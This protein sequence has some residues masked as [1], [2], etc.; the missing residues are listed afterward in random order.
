M[1]GKLR[2]LVRTNMVLY[3]LLLLVF[4]GLTA[5]LSPLLAAGEVAAALLVWYVSRRRNKVMQ[6]QLHQYVERISGGA[7]TAKTSNML[8]APMP[9][10]VFNPDSEDVLWANDLFAELPGV[11]E[12]IYESRVRD[13]VKGFETHW[14][15]EGKPE[16]P[17]VFTWN[18][19][20]YRVFGCLSQ[21]EEKGRFGVLATTYWMDVTDLEHM[22]S[23]LEETKPVAAIV[24]IDNYE[25]LM[26]ACPE[27]KRSAIRAA[28][29]EKMDQWRGTSGALLMKYD[30][31]RYL[32]VFTE[33]QYEAFA[34][35]RFAILDEV[36]TVQAAEGCVCHHVHRRGPGG[37]ELRRTVQK[38]GSGAGDGP[39]PGRRPGRGKGPDEFRVLRRTGQDHGKAHKGE[40]PGHG[41][42]LGRP[43][44]RNGA[45]VCYGPPVR[46]HGYPGRGGGCVRHCP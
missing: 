38:C 42:R 10:M 39:E 4:A 31:D 32:M 43:D 23:T 6:Q 30:R 37:R 33:K 17:G 24:M 45:C 3:I 26:S 9:M 41:Q 15:M 28:I 14:L 46:R 34:Q 40:V 7:D 1:N 27:G 44:G 21:P 25:D 18:D 16:Y 5:R 35:G 11:G 12:N 36:R 20:R 29:E 22:R 19:R 13:V 2:K 8:F